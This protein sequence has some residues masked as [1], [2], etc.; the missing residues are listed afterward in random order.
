MV[1]QRLCDTRFIPPRT[2]NYVN[3]G[4]VMPRLSIGNHVS[5]TESCHIDCAGQMVIEDYVLMAPRIFITDSNHGMD[6]LDPKGYARQPLDIKNVRI[7][8]GVWLGDGVKVMPGVTIGAHSIIGAG[9]VVTR[10][11]P[12]Y[13]VAAGA[14]ARVIKRWDFEQSEWV[15]A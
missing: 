5:C 1:W 3:W 15:R 7:C 6:P 12:E 8:E 14:P 9:S 2:R 4:G 13:S 10:D 11:I